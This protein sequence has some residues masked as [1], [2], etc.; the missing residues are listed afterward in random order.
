MGKGTQFG[1]FDPNRG[2][3]TFEL[4]SRTEFAST[5]FEGILRWAMC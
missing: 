3:W 2:R 1:I 4:G 5:F